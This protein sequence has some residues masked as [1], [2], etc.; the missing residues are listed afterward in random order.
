MVHIL[1]A[2]LGYV[3]ENGKEDKEGTSVQ[4]KAPALGDWDSHIHTIN[5]MCERDS[6]KQTFSF[7]YSLKGLMLK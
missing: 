7:K 2:D 3:A 5:T 4:I 6:I 1:Q